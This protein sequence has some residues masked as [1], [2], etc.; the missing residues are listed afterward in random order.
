MLSFMFLLFTGAS[1]TLGEAWLLVVLCGDKR[2]STK[3]K[4]LSLGNI[5]MLTT[6]FYRQKQLVYWPED[7]FVCLDIFF[8]IE[9]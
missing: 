3:D 8:V 9:M 1:C 7:T 2:G 5:V 6:T 4:D